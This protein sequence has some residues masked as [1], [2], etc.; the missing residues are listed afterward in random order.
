LF[1]DYAE[2]EVVA[3]NGGDGAV[4][5]RREKYVPKGGPDGGDGGKGGNVYIRASDDLSTLLDFR[6][7]KVFRA[8]DGV[9]GGKSNKSGEGGEDIHIDLPVGTVV[10][11]LKTDRV[12]ADLTS[13]GMEAL[14]ARGGKGGKGNT[15]FKSST[16]QT[17]RTAEKGRAGERLKVSL[18]LK[19]IADVGLVGFPNAGKST[20]LSRLSAAHPKI[21]DYP[22]TTRVPN[23]GIV[24]MR[25]Y[26]SFVLADIPGLI[27]GAH[28]GKGMG[29]Q[30][31]RHIQRTRIIV[32]LI[33]ITSHRPT[34][35][36]EIL[37][38]EMVSFDPRL[39]EKPSIT[40][41]NK[42]D[43]ISER[44]VV[45]GGLGVDPRE[46]FF[47][48]AATGENIDILLDC[49]SRKLFGDG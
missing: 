35:E 31:L 14:L 25:G 7:K 37:K 8:P 41:F 11:D 1:V 43:L 26:R 13:D 27:E 19:S 23:L 6:Y 16:N 42:I 48:S 33:D 28:L 49:L 2:I 3:G 4:S 18:E 34:D 24:P 44:P 21:A 45:V 30:F 12:L 10:K 39:L 32:Y 15:R 36:L 17:P 38:K 20:L 22:F 47:I 40:A 5:F 9:R 29:T 46:V